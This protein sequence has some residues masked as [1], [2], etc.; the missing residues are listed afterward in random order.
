M[1]HRLALRNAR[2]ATLAAA[3]KVFLLRRPASSE[4]SFFLNLFCSMSR[5]GHM[6]PPKLVCS[7]FPFRTL[8]YFLTHLAAASEVSSI[9]ESRISG[10]SIGGNVEETGRVLSRSFHSMASIQSS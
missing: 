7:E 1:L 5:P 3:P 4:P 10:S 9:L 2:V 8:A 6:L